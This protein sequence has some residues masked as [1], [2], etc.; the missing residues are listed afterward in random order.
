MQFTLRKS[1]PA[2]IFI[3]ALLLSAAHALAAQF[4]A[5]EAAP[6]VYAFIGD[7]A[8]R[9][10]ENEGMNTNTGFIVT[11]VGVVVIDSGASYQAAK[12]M[13]AA[14]RKVTS[15]PVRYVI[16][17]GGQDHRWLGNGYFK[18]Q[19]AQIIAS[20]KAL[21]DMKERGAE[22]LL[23][24]KPV[25]REKLVGT[26]IVYPDRLFERADIFKMGNTEIQILFFQG[27]HTP[28]DAVVWL[29]KFRVLF[30]GD[31][32]FV[33][34]LLGIWPFSNSKNWLS[35]FEQI[36]KLQP[37]VIIPGHGKICDLA[38]ARR[39]TR[40]YLAM[41]RKHMRES[42]LAGYDLQKAIDTLDQSAYRRLENYEL[43]KGSNASSVYLEMESE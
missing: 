9:S 8:N 19:D 28:G 12:N 20:Q 17:T 7:T 22:E 1:S 23:A 16:N 29:P 15:Q 14:I 5:V 21:E 3:F 32:I 37:R 41:L 38:L 25:L 35:S 18:E 2:L 4:S 33:E 30:A 43:L 13:H 40:D 39:D 31:L 11:N 10:Y 6:G 24:L 42:Y 36:E 34:R 27:G 26:Q